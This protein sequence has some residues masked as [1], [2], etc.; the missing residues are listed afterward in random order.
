MTCIDRRDFLKAAAA[1]YLAAAQT[2][3]PL[4]PSAHRITDAAYTPVRDYPIQ[5][6]R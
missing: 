4:E 6:K 1:A 2:K 5:P 3:P